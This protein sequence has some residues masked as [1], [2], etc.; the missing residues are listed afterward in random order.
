MPRSGYLIAAAFPH[1]WAN[2]CSCR[3]HRRLEQVTQPD[4]LVSKHRQAKHR[5]HLASAAQLEL[6]QPAPLFDPDKQLLE[7]A[8]GIDWFAV[9][10]VAGGMAIDGGAIRTCGVLRHVGRHDNAAHL[11]DKALGVVILVG[12]DGLLVGT[13]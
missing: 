6:A 5:T 3:R 9:A 1:L 10:L 11:G 7:A 2:R 8:A 12:A 4:Q 13:G